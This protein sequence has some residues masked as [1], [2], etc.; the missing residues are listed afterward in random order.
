MHKT[1]LQ[2]TAKKENPKREREKE[3]K[4]NGKKER[5]NFERWK[6]KQKRESKGNVTF[7]SEK[8]WGEAKAEGLLGAYGQERF[9]LLF[10]FW[11]MIPAIR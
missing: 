11:V 7:V 9:F 4:K 5:E 2:K 1:K 3:R 6:K 8:N 10:H